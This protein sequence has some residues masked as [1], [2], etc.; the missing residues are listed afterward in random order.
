LVAAV[1]AVL[2]DLSLWGVQTPKA[3]SITDGFENGTGL[4]M[5]SRPDRIRTLDSK[6]P[7]HGHVLLLESDGDDVYAMLKGTEAWRGARIDADVQFPTDENNLL[8]IIYNYRKRG[9]RTDFGAVYIKGNDNYLQGNPHRDLNVSRTFYPEARAPLT[10]ARAFHAGAWQHIRVEVVGQI[11]HFFVGDLETPALTFPLFENEAGAIG[12]QPR[13]V[14]GPVWVDNVVVQ[15]IDRLSYTGPAQPEAPAYSRSSFLTAWDVA[16]PFASTRDSLARDPGAD[17]QA[18]RP[19]AADPRGAVVTGAIT[20]FHGPNT[21]AYFRTTFTA[22]AGVAALEFSTID[23]LALW[24]NGR[25][26]WF[27]LRDSAAWFD[28][29]TNPKHRGQSIPIDVRAGANEIV[30]RARGGAYAT[31]GFFVRLLR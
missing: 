30:L 21:V 1:I 10:G 23:D 28:S 3:V 4:W 11:C 27:I 9:A 8:G 2:L 20:D 13:S 22:D 7:K 29:P 6:D 17:R 16:G 31:G 14:G 25:F 5:V 12:L 18:W 19:L 15:P 24:V 26:A